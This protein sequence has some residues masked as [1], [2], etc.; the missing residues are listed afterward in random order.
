M[1]SDQTF[2]NVGDLI[3]FDTEWGVTVR[4]TKAQISTLSRILKVSAILGYVLASF[5]AIPLLI[6]LFFFP[7]AEGMIW[8]TL[9]VLGCIAV[10]G[11]F[12][13]QSKKGP[14]NAIQIDYAASEVRLGSQM[15][16][17]VFVRHRVCPFRHIERISID[18]TD[19]SNPAICLQL[20]D[21]TVKVAFKDADIRSLEIVAVKLSA[22]RQSAQKAPVVERVRSVIFGIDAATREVGQ[23][24]RSRVVS[25]AV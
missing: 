14:R 5:I 21:E 18:S 12:Q 10:A 15:A 1:D 8:T 25:R 24:V 7:E 11:F 13:A 19:R 22:A 16:N 2:G 6:G 20:N 3:N 17:G 9:I 23:R 4:E